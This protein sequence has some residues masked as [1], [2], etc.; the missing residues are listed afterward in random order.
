LKV[1]RRFGGKYRLAR[2]QRK[3]STLLATCFHSGF[4]I[5]L[6]F[7]PEDGGDTFLNVG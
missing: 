6:F 2:N 3:G 4:L 1:N 5:G 7:D